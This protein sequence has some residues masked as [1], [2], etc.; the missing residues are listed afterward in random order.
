MNKKLLCL[1][2]ALVMLLSL[3]ACGGGNAPPADPAQTPAGDTQT[4]P[5]G[6][7]DAAPAEVTDY[8]EMTR[9]DDEIYEMVFG[10]FY[11]AYMTAKDCQELSQRYALM[12]IA[13]AKMLESAIMMP[14]QS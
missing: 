14:K 9:D 11:D 1:L 13:E 4:P 2:L 5:E 7:G 8:R 3:A 12:G 6:D 10:D